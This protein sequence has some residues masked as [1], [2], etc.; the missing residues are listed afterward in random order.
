MKGSSLKGVILNAEAISYIDSSAA[1]LLARIIEEI[2]NRGIQFYI[3]GAIG[4]TRDVIFRSQII[5]V[6]QK[7]FLFVE[8]KEAVHYFDNPK[9]ETSVGR[10]VA[11]Q[12]KANGN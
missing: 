11:Y 12:N 6:L 1:Q 2:H 4:P 10:M 3:A 8:T 5:N 7:E 9:P